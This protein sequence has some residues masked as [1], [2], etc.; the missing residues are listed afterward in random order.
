MKELVDTEGNLTSG[1][2]KA[3]DHIFKKYDLD[4][5]NSL[6]PAELAAFATATNG[7]PFTTEDLD[8]IHMYFTCDDN[9]LTKQ[10]FYEMYHT[11]SMADSSETWRDLKA[12]GV[13]DNFEIDK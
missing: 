9:G 7:A 11:Q 10:G 12:H 2:A 8:E 6:C 13:G 4:L 5:D 3:L 1:L